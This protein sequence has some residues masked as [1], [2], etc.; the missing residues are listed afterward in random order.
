MCV[1]KSP[2]ITPVSQASTTQPKPVVINNRYLDGADPMLKAQ[3]QGR[4]ALRIERTPG[5]G[6]TAAQGLPAASVRQ[7]LGIARGG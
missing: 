1:V 5:A 4:S 6:L 2:K 7:R 3:R